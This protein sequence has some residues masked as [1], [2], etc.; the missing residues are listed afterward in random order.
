MLKFSMKNHKVIIDPISLTLEPLL[1]IWVA[2]KSANKEAATK[3]LTYVHICSQVDQEAPFAK[4]D[5]TEVGSLAKREI[6]GKY[7]YEFKGKF[8]EE[9]MESTVMRYQMAYDTPEQAAVRIYDKKI[10]EINRVIDETEIEIKPVAVRGGIDYVSNFPII[11]KMMQ[12]MTKINAAKE[13][14]KAA[15]MKQQSTSSVRGQ[16]QVS[17]LEKRR[18]EMLKAGVKRATT[19]RKEAEDEEEEEEDN[20]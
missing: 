6:F 11:N 17:F 13:A 9:F 3:L 8:D 10:Y 14:L 2:D 12:D 18:A 7:D 4:V 19:A 5:P 16:R 1:E 15:V 20:F